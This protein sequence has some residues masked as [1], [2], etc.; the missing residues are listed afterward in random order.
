[1]SKLDGKVAIITGGSSGIGYATAKRFAAEGA[2]VF[3]TGRRE[4]ELKKAARELGPQVT[5]LRGD[6]AKLED[7]DRIYKKVAHDA[8][9]ID[10]VIAN[11]AFVELRSL[12]ES[13]AAHFD[14]IFGT[15]V[16]GTFFTVQKALP[17]LRNG[18]SIVLVTTS[19]HVKGVPTYGSYLATKAA[20]RAYARTWAAELKDRT[21]RVNT[22]SPG[23]IDTPI[24]ETVHKRKDLADGAR[25]AFKS[26]IPMGRL[27]TADDVA[28]SIL[29]LASDDSS[30]TTGFDLFVDGGLSQ[31]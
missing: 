18:G 10:I 8:D 4:N 14:K 5:A 7:L 31:L 29:Y 12:E 2:Q 24:F 16:R 28:A 27:G 1:M 17:L 9:A 30:F 6:I 22:V 21:I 15:N 20:L 25:E 3:I 11:A 26:A 19:G 13:E 23:P